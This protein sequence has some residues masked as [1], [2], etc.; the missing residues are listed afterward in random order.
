MKFLI[1]K[2]VT[3]RSEDNIFY[4][5]FFEDNRIRK[6][7]ERLIAFRQIGDIINKCDFEYDK[8]SFFACSYENKKDY[9]EDIER[10]K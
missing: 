5:V 4:D 3:I 2:K 10:F 9:E 1:I 6:F 8:I 7:Q